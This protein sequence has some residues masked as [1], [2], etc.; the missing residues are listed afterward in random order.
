MNLSLGNR[1][2]SKSSPC[3]ALPCLALP[4]FFGVGNGV[5]CIAF[6]CSPISAKIKGQ[7]R[8]EKELH[9]HA[10]V[11][12]STTALKRNGNQ[13]NLPTDQLEPLCIFV[14]WGKMD[15]CVKRRCLGG[16]SNGATML[17]VSPLFMWLSFNG[18]ARLSCSC[19][20]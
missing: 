12:S 2:A 6:W 8:N 16:R 5:E 3:R 4:L 17:R 15:S 7:M 10:K 1:T 19:R 14:S 18:F 9:W 20:L 11:E 13:L